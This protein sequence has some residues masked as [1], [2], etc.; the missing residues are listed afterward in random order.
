MLIR[1]RYP[2]TLTAGCCWGA[3]SGSKQEGDLG[4]PYA[5]ELDAFSSTF[6]W[7]D[8]QDVG[9]LEHFLNRWSGDHVAVVGSG[10]SYSAAFVVSLFCELVHHSPTTP[11]TPLEFDAMLRRLGVRAAEPRI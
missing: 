4:K 7:V 5:I 3:A 9:Q 11:V 10:G 1:R 6:E 8:R 2:V